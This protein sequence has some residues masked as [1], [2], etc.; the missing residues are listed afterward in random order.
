MMKTCYMQIEVIE[1]LKKLFFMFFFQYLTFIAF[2]L[3]RN[4]QNGVW[5]VGKTTFWR[6][7]ETKKLRFQY[8]QSIKK[9][10]F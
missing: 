3:A 6:D 7:V 10:F 1:T 2:N 8:S 9:L 4:L 5:K